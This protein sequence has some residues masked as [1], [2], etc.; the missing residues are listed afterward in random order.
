MHQL[1]ATPEHPVII[2]REA[3]FPGAWGKGA[4]PAEAAR[5]IRKHGARDGATVY[6]MACSANAS[7]TDM[8]DLA[9]DGRGPI[10]KGKLYARGIAQ[11]ELYAEARPASEG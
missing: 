8:G 6:G 1:I 4:T 7:I 11:P 9:S 3:R 5:N 10:L 2:L